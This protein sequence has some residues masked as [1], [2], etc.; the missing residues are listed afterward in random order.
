MT[1]SA[2]GRPSDLDGLDKVLCIGGG[3]GTAPLYPQIKY[4]H[5]NGKQVDVIIGAGTRNM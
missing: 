1:L 5:E 3:V 4:L 2:L